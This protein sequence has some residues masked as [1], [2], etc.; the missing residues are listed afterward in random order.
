MVKRIRFSVALVVAI[1]AL[2]IGR[3][4][5]N[6]FNMAPPNPPGPGAEVQ[7]PAISNITAGT[8]GLWAISD[9]QCFK[10]LLLGG[11]S[12]IPVPQVLTPAANVVMDLSK[13]CSGSI[14]FP[15]AGQS[16]TLT[17]TNIPF[18]SGKDVSVFTAQPGSGTTNNTVT[19][20]TGFTANSTIPAVHTGTSATDV[21]TFKDSGSLVEYPSVGAN[22]PVA[23]GGAGIFA[24][25][26]LG[27]PAAT[28]GTLTIS[29]STSGTITIGSQPTAVGT[30]NLNFPITSGALGDILL[31]GGGSTTAQ[32]WLTDV[33]VGRVLVSG[34]I[35]TN[36]AY[37]AVPQLG[38]PGTTS[39]TLSLSNATGSGY[40]TLAQ[41]A[42]T[43]TYTETTK[44]VVPAQGDILDY[45]NGSGQRSSLVDVAVG[46]V[47]VSGGVGAVP[48]YSAS[49]SVTKVTTTGTG[50]EE[51]V[52]SGGG[53]F[54][55]LL[56]AGSLPTVGT[57]TVTA[58][59]TD[60]AMEV[61]GATSPA[62][63][64]FTTP[65]HAQPICVCGDETAATGVCKAVPN[66]N[67]QTVVITTAATDSFNLV[68]VGK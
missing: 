17:A 6:T 21:I 20:S 40:Y 44:A 54:S 10:G 66:S 32:T 19:F 3:A 56:A 46:Q 61:T 64:T 55:S 4:S 1:L 30:Y 43:T 27:T 5:A 22:A 13:G 2:T 36:P 38:V 50:D 16:I 8:N 65:F 25:M 58:G 49:P 31:S 9:P 52:V 45:S 11:W 59:G 35:A 41:A 42:T 39:G 60:T 53:H 48:V 14:A 23:T 7:C 33:A 47:I 63:V 12:T 28:Q 15:I 26:A 18:C 57:G 67:G 62:T 51:M 34:G 68:C 37:S 29:G 24:T